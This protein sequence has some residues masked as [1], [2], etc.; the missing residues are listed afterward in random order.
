MLE[1]PSLS[2]A[3]VD[4]QWDFGGRLACFGDASYRYDAAGRRLEQTRGGVVTNYAYS[5]A[6]EGILLEAA[7]SDGSS[8]RYIWGMGLIGYER[9]DGSYRS[10]RYDSRGSVVSLCNEVGCVVGMSC[11]T[12]QGLAYMRTGEL[13]DSP[14]GFCAQHGVRDDGD[15]LLYMRARYYSPAIGRF[16]SPDSWSGDFSDPVTLNRYLYA[17]GNPV[18]LIDPWG[19]SAAIS[20]GAHLALDAAG[21]LPV[22]GAVFDAA[23]GVWYLAEGDW[24]DAG[25]SFAAAA[26]GAGDALA[27]VKIVGKGVNVAQ[28]EQRSFKKRLAHQSGKEA[29]TDIPSWARGTAP[30]VGESGREYAKRVMDKRYGIDNYSKDGGEYSRLKKYGDRAFD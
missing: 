20:S 26:P 28:L 4:V 5:S 24:G 22:A 18:T 29:A 21:F 1:V 27:G 9:Q 2:G 7:G 23:N 15:G 30:Y 14:L 19:R 11:Y 16:I 17:N 6:G 12:V 3:C 8:E 25:L 13:A 10:L